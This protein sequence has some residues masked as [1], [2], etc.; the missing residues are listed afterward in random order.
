MP[1]MSPKSA[2]FG[3]ITFYSYW[4][5]PLAPGKYSVSVKP[6][7]KASGKEIP[8]SPVTETFHIGGPRY[9]L[10]G[11]EIYSCYP[12][13]GQIGQ[14]DGTLP[15]IVFDRCTLPWER[16]ID[17]TDPTIKPANHEPYPWLALILLTDAD[18]SNE[19]AVEK[20]RVPPIAPRRLGDVLKPEKNVIGPNLKEDPYDDP[21]TDPCQTIDLPASVFRT[22]MPRMA[23]LPYLAHVREIKTDN[24][25][26]WSL[27]KEGRFSVVV[28]NR[29]P[30]SQ[31]TAAGEK[32]WGIV[33]T[34]CLVSLEGWS[35]YLN[36]PRSSD[37]EQ[38]YRLVVLGSWRFTC[39]G[40]S[41]FKSQMLH[42]DDQHLLA[43]P[44]LVVEERV[45]E[46]ESRT[47]TYINKALRMGFAPVNHD[48]RN[49]DR[50]ISWYR[51]PL[52]PMFYERSMSYP[53]ISCGDA[54]LRYTPETGIFDTSY[55][56]AWQLGRLLAL[57]DQSFAQALFRFRNDYQ[58][59]DRTTNTEAL[60]TMDQ[61]Q[62][63][64]GNLRD[65]YATQ[66][67]PVG[68]LT[69]GR[70]AAPV[71]VP[72]PPAIPA[73]VQSWISQAM[74]LY[75]V[76]FHYL[77]PDAEM[78]PA[79][80]IRFFYLNPEW[81]NSL[82]QG[83]CS[84]GRTSVSDELA[85]QL[86]RAH[87]FKLS[88]KLASELRSNAKQEAVR[89]R[90]GNAHKD[91]P[92][93]PP[94]HRSGWEGPAEPVLHWP[95][96]GYLLRSGVVESWIGLEATAKG[97]DSAGNSL[98]PLQ[99]LRM[100]RLAPD[101]L[102]CIYNGKVT[103]IELKQPPE[104]IHFGAASK[105]EGGHEKTGLRKIKGDSQTMGDMCEGTIRIDVPT[106]R[107]RVVNVAELA[108]KIKDKLI[109]SAQVREGDSFTSAEFAVEMLESPAKVAF[110]EAPKP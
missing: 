70:S 11:S 104:A 38:T 43:R 58:R 57:Q 12:A 18:F 37:A 82:L 91:M 103:Q 7:L 61:Q 4:L 49:G 108:G 67:K 33:N 32:D 83:A 87:F 2:Q 76:P 60:D 53:D 45:P 56:A 105:A 109:T 23:D 9:A 88:E 100:D 47:L 98:D 72:G 62:A 35:E 36:D 68:F 80:S 24:K 20:Q 78:L 81:I 28:C 96:S 59:W 26:T 74:L 52:V 94:T 39:Q 51:G 69:S 107:Q 31:A 85:D 99:I 71:Q 77:V 41:D 50:T 48:L 97:K 95:L 1:D 93:S 25:E 15:H 65:W 89:R 66:L 63:D 10:T 110:F 90:D 21:D 8:S 55:A 79:E 73:T 84:V 75:G 22:V 44:P 106:S 42:L 5:P 40:R 13:T 14:F 30:E 27:L 19:T 34:V 17:S 92:V 54:A 3:Q 86:L 101:I 46:N 16:T 102:L 29:F 64:S 6:T